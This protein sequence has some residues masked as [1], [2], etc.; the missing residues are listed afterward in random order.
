MFNKKLKDRHLKKKALQQ[1]EDPLIIDELPSDDEWV[2]GNENEGE[3]QTE[4]AIDN[5]DIDLFEDG[6]GTSNTTRAQKS[7]KKKRTG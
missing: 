3:I 1:D 4:E 2:A 6:E 7:S 5:L